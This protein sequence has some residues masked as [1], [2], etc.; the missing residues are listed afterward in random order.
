MNNGTAYAKK[1]EEYKEPIEKI[2]NQVLNPKS[3]ENE[4][5]K[6]KF[7]L[8]QDA[9]SKVD[10]FIPKGANSEFFSNRAMGDWAEKIV[11]DLITTS[12]SYKVVHYGDSDRISAEDDRF[13]EAYLRKMEDTRLYGKRPDLLLMENSY[14]GD[15]DVSLKR[16]NENDGIANVAKYA[17]EVRSSKFEAETYKARKLEKLTKEN[18]KKIKDETIYYIASDEDERIFKEYIDARKINDNNEKEL[19][20]L[21]Y[22]GKKS[23][24]KIDKLCQETQKILSKKRE[25][26]PEEKKR[27]TSKIKNKYKTEEAKV[28][29]LKFTVK[30]EDLRIVYR[31]IMRY[32]VP[33]IYVQVFFDSIYAINVLKI[34]EIIA[35]GKENWPKF[36]KIDNPQK[37]QEKTTIVIPISEGVQIA[38]CIKDENTKERKLPKFDL[39]EKVTSLGRH[40]AYV[41]PSGGEYSLKEDEFK[42]V[43]D[44]FPTT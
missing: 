5:G 16:T 42:K 35:K 7:S 32:K 33:Q 3:N 25:V 43:L 12:T 2:L 28:E 26:S 22:T 29:V 23:Q 21:Q 13:R 14:N 20:N 8:S 44:Y 11:S 4:K 10:I 37:S 36:M 31:W 1:L 27:I 38:E 17:I 6:E 18:D 34:F 24:E 40:D 15:L 9:D 19:I 41:I 30:V 39:G